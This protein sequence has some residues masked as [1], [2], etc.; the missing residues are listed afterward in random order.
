MKITIEINKGNAAFEDNQFEIERVL[1]QA[2]D[3]VKG[4]FLAEGESTPLHDSNGARCGW[5]TLE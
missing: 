4:G 3:A 5:V 2:V 1:V